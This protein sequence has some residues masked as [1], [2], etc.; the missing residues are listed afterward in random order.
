[1]AFVISIDI[2]K[3]MQLSYFLGLWH[4]HGGSGGQA[5]RYDSDSSTCFSSTFNV[6]VVL[7][8][9]MQTFHVG[10]MTLIQNQPT[11]FGKM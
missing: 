7:L 9:Y 8:F 1:M 10:A 3:A 6:F 4:V 2:Y 11:C 5:P